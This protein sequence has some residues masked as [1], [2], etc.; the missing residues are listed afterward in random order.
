MNAEPAPRRRRGPCP[1]VTARKVRI[2]ADVEM[3]TKTIKEIALGAGC[4]PTL[5]KQVIN[6]AGYRMRLVTD[7]EFKAL[8]ETRKAQR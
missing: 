4:S 6:G 2:L 7:V 1:I 5:A 3:G 8:V